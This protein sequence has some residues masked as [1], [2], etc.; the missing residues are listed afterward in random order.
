MPVCDERNTLGYPNSCSAAGTSHAKRTKSAGVARRQIRS[1]PSRARN[2][3]GCRLRASVMALPGN[4]RSRLQCPSTRPSRAASR[5]ATSR[6]GVALSTTTGSPDS[7]TYTSPPMPRA[8]RP[9]RSCCPRCYSSTFATAVSPKLTD[10]SAG[11]FGALRDALG[12]LRERP[13]LLQLGFGFKRHGAMFGVEL[14][15]ERCQ[16]SR[17]C[18]SPDALLADAKATGLDVAMRVVGIRPVRDRSYTRHNPGPVASLFAGLA[19]SLGD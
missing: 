7:R 4:A 10:Q 15:H 19:G 16:N 14:D 17:S 5:S 2:P 8:M 6:W 18:T 11:G 12:A 9:P 1:A 13:V 3:N